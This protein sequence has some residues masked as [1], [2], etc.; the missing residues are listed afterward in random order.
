MTTDDRL[1]KAERMAEEILAI[2]DDPF[3]D[4]ADVAAA[5]PTTAKAAS[6][7]EALARAKLRIDVRMW[8][9]A[10]LAPQLYGT[11]AGNTSDDDEPLVY[12]N[13]H[14]TPPGDLKS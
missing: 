8:L 3:A 9:M 4:M 6:D 14:T 10:R 5:A 2:A 7:R 1:A 11:G 12:F 13:V